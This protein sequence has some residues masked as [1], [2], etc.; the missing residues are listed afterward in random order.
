MQLFCPACQSAFPGVSRC[1]RCGGLLLMPHE[2]SPDAPHRNPEAPPPPAHPTAGGRVLLGSVLALG[3]YLGARQLATAAV[4]AGEPDPA[5]WWLSL[6]GLS[7]VHAAQAVAVMFG[8]LIAATGRPA[9]YALGLA[10]GAVC[11]GLFLGFELYTGAPARDLVLY[12][13]VPVLALLGLVAGVVGARV[14]GMAPALD[15]PVPHPSKLSSLQLGSD[16]E[17]DRGRPT[18]WV[19]VLAG[20][21]VMVLGVMGADEARRFL[22]RN[23]AGLLRVESLAQGEFITWQIATFMVLMGGV[24]AGA[25]TGAGLRHGLLVGAIGGAG[26]FGLCAKAGGAI[27]PVEYWLEKLALDGYALTAGPAIFAIVGG[28]VAVALVGGWLGGAPLP[29]LAPPR[30]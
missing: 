2:V 14:W 20:A 22:Q 13:Q 24:T 9:G 5:G 1:P 4:L 30:V 6:R 10:V 29:R 18:R 27:A 28:V 23:S 3:M 19:R 15:I 7:V 25:A 26:V 8:A 16:V 12:L 21:A 11:G 17:A